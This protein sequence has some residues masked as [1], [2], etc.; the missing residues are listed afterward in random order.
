[1]LRQVSG[2]RAGPGCPS[3]LLKHAIEH[4]AIVVSP[5]YR[6]LP[7]S[8][9]VDI[10]EDLVD[11]SRWLYTDLPN[12][13][14]N[15]AK[16]VIADVGNILVAGE[17]AGGYLAVQSA[18]L[19]PNPAIKVVVCAYGILDVKTRF[20]TQA[21]EKHIIG[22]QGMAPPGMIDEHIGSIRPGTMISAVD[23]SNIRKRIDLAIAMVQ[24]GRYVEFLGSES[25]LFPVENLERATSLPP[26]FVFH[27]KEDTAV[28]FEGSEAFVSM[29]KEAHPDANIKLS[30]VKGDHLFD[31]EASSGE[32]W[33]Q[34][35]LAFISKYW[36]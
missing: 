18:L 21:Y 36:L 33:L 31:M 24:Q 5:D 9:G 35:G 30:I 14:S 19:H 15:L 8:K 32:L 7:E 17:S 12:R 34:E 6:L 26:M 3:W 22:Y 20:F 27:G 11:F 28:P 23:P 13:V 25:T 2:A 29:A 16:D 4:S 1:M 10:L